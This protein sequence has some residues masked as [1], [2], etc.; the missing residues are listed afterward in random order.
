MRELANRC[1]SN[2]GE[3]AIIQ[4][5]IYGI[6][7]PGSDK[8]IIYAATLF[9]EFKQKLH[10]YETVIKNMGIHNSNSPDFRHSY[11]SRRRDTKQQTF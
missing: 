2:I 9:F 1:D 3:A 7:G 5:V 8:I 11:D 6:D 10:S 4:Y